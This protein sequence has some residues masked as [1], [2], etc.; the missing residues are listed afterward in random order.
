M[1]AEPPFIAM[2]AVAVVG[3]VTIDRNR[4]AGR[5]LFKLGGVSSYAG[6]TYRRH[7]L[8]TRVV[9]NVAQA[10]AAILA[11]LRAAGLRILNGRTRHTTRFVNRTDAT[12]RT[13]AILSLAAPI[14]YRRI[15]A[16]LHRVDCLHLGPL[17]PED[18]EAQAYAFIKGSRALVVLDVQGLVRK[19]V[20]GRLVAAVSDHLAAALHAASVVKAD[21]AEAEAICSAFG[22]GIE[23][24]ME[25]FAIAEWVVTGGASG[26]CIHLHGRRPQP[27]EAA[28]VEGAVDPTGAGDVFLAAYTVARF[29]LR[30]SAAAASRRA[31]QL[32]AEH[33]AGRLFPADLL[34]LGHLTAAQRR[35]VN[36][37]NGANDV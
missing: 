11:P 8:P 3:S 31:A 21:Q 32:S 7:G 30:L 35:G 13:Q 17:H 33:V 36:V 2:N 15:A 5:S 34:D 37:D 19:S 25:Q 20:R 12:G 22:L 27:Y 23:A 4:I 14:G 16:V 1:L 29:Q 10:E 28:P 18:I 6:L 9:C 24:L 26:G